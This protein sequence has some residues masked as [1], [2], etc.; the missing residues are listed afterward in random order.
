MSTNLAG[1]RRRPPSGRPRTP[2]SNHRPARE[3]AASGTEKKRAAIGLERA[4]QLAT[5]IVAPTTVLTALLFYFGWVRTNALFQYFGVDATVLGFTTQDYLLRSSEALYIPLG[6]L[7][8]VGLAGLW[9]HGLMTTW[10]AARRRLRLLRATAVALGVVGLALFAR[11]VAGVAVPRLSLND[12]L[13]TPVCLGLGA[14]LGAYGHW[15]WLRQRA[16]QGHDGSPARPRWHGVVSLVLVV[17]LVVLSLF[18]ATTN[19]ARAY[20]RGRAAAYARQLAV[21]PGVIVYSADRLFLHG[22]GVQELALPAQQHTSYR[23]RYSGLRLTESHGRLFLLPE[24]WTRT[25]G[26]AIVLA[27]SDKLRVEFIRGLGA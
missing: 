13:V 1:H 14:V 16:V 5:A 25:D 8:V 10:L 9:V 23:Y 2:A 4:V 17:L 22:P 19:Y 27:G 3:P 18:W 26:A 7:L 20:G 6:T 11:G 15:L 21:R 12:F 24:G